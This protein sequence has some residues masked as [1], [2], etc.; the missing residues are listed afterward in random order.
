[1]EKYAET[2]ED[3]NT[4]FLKAGC[5]VKNAFGQKLNKTCEARVSGTNDNPII[6]S[7]IVY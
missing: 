7:F 3:E 4:W 5:T 1:M 6:E 2:A